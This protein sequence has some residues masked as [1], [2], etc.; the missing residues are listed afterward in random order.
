MTPMLPRA[1][2]PRRSAL[3]EG[4][5]IASVWRRRGFA[6]PEL[7]VATALA[8]L[9]AGAILAVVHP[10]SDAFLRVP[11]VGDLHQRVRAAAEVVNARLLGA[12]GAGPSGERNP[13]GVEVP[14]LFPYGIGA[15][16]AATPGDWVA[17]TLSVLTALPATVPATLRLP[18]APGDTRAELD[19]SRCPEASPAC[20]I[21]AGDALALV[22]P[23]GRSELTQ[24]AMVDGA[25]ITLTRRG[26]ASGRSFPAGSLAIAADPVVLYVRDATGTDPPQLRRHDGAVSDLPLLDHVVSFS[27]RFFG[28]SS[29]PSVSRDGSSTTYGPLPPPA[30]IDDPEDAWGP[31]ENCV[32]TRVDGAAVSRLP[33]LGGNLLGL[34]ELSPPVLTDGPWCP[35]A[36]SPARFDADLLRVRRARISLRLEAAPAQL[37]GRGTFFMRPGTSSSGLRL[38]PDRVVSFEVVPRGAGGGR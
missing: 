12:C 38:V 18:L 32:F 21:R 16:R 7:L 2:L 17:A 36:A 37:R 24:A 34:V 20:G 3:R 35:D 5:S 6:L 33:N 1:A 8:V 9:I 23:G 29:A 26:P 15:R 22:G 14:C 4:G 30:G 11:A 13:L 31:G 19:R 10:S 27:V 25:S 28:E